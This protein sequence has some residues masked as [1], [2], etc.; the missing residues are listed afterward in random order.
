MEKSERETLHRAL[1]ERRLISKL[2]ERVNERCGPTARSN[3]YLAFEDGATS[4][5]R[6][7]ILEEAQSLLADVTKEIAVPA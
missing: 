6:L 5:L 1:S 3:I 2:H 7:A 4:A